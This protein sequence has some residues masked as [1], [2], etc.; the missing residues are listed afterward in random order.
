MLAIRRYGQFTSSGLQSIGDPSDLIRATA[1]LLI[2]ALGSQQPGGQAGLTG[3]ESWPELLPTLLQCI[4]NPS[5][6]VVLGA[7]SS[8]QKVCEDSTHEMLQMEGYS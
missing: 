5:E 3:L 1:G 2:T 6:H 8:L 7:F 4:E